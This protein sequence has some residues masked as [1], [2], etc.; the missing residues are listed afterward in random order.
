MALLAILMGIYL[1]FQSVYERKNGS[2][3]LERKID[4]R[5]RQFHTQIITQCNKSRVAGCEV[6]NRSQMLLLCIEAY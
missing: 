2:G 3:A 6:E 5:I 1:Y 4:S